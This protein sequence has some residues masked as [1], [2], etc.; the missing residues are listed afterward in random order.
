MTI[1]KSLA[2]V[3]QLSADILGHIFLLNVC[4]EHTGSWKP[5]FITA[6]ATSQVCQQWRDVAISLPQLWRNIEIKERSLQWTEELIN[7]SQLYPLQVR[8]LSENCSPILDQQLKPKH[9]TRLHSF[10]GYLSESAWKQIVLDLQKPTSQL[11]FLDIQNTNTAV[12]EQVDISKTQSSNLKELYIQPDISLSSPGFNLNSPLFVNLSILSITSATFNADFL[13]AA[14]QPMALLT[15]LTLS[16]SLDQ[17]KNVAVNKLLRVSL[18]NLHYLLIEDECVPVQKILTCVEVPESCAIDA[19]IEGAVLGRELTSAASFVF[20]RIIRDNNSQANPS[21]NFT[22]TEEV[23]S[24]SSTPPGPYHSGPWG[25]N[26]KQSNKRFS[27]L[28]LTYEGYYWLNYFR[29]FTSSL[30]TIIPRTKCLS[31]DLVDLVDFDNVSQVSLSSF[32]AVTHFVLKN[33]KVMRQIITLLSDTSSDNIVF[34]FL[35]KLTLMPRRDGLS[36]CF[37]DVVTCLE[38][39]NSAG[40]GIKTLDVCPEW[41]A[42]NK[43]PFDDAMRAKL[44]NLTK[45]VPFYHIKNGLVVKTSFLDDSSLDTDNRGVLP[46]ASISYDWSYRFYNHIRFFDDCPCCDES[47]DTYDG[48]G[49]NSYF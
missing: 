23:I 11:E 35:D 44:E 5:Y 38:N 14:L 6:R 29:Y 24:F 20:K 15:E 30:E 1:Q 16:N 36:R 17:F 39:R 7:R 43:G 34:P 49:G 4:N 42:Y 2:A 28:R 13:L 27:K 32:S 41:Y 22:V 45:V 19:A 46:F 3:S 10:V 26:D 21:L 25:T 9:I 37:D 18:P 12:F 40:R 47:Y 48:L 33:D 8:C 31:V